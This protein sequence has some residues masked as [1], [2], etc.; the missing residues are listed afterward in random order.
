M[1]LRK[2]WD[3]LAENGAQGDWYFSREDTYITIRWGHEAFQVATIPISTG[4]KSDR[5]WLWDGNKDAPTIQPSIR[6]LGGDGNPDV[7]HGWLT[8]GALI[9]A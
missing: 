8:K 1:P 2:D 9:T 7:W 6:I 3:D 4:E 5:F